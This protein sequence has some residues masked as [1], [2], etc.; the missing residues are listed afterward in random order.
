MTAHDGLKLIAFYLP[1]FHPI[2]ENDAWWGKG[3]TE[4]RNVAKGRPLFRGHYQPH[5]PADLGF[6]DLRLEDTRIAQAELARAHG[7]NGFCYYHYWFNGRELLERPFNEVL[8]SRQPDF[9]ICL[10]WANENWTRRWDGL[11]HDVLLG[12]NYS[13]EDDR[14]HIRSLFPAFEDSRYL[15][16]DGKPLFLVYRVGLFPEPRATAE[17]WREEASKAGIGEIFL[18]SVESIGVRKTPMDTGFDAA[19]EFA[20]D[21][22]VKGD[23]INQG[24]FPRL[25][26]KFG[27]KDFRR[28]NVYSYDSLVE[29]MLAKPLPGYKQFRGV[30]P[31]W[32]KTARRQGQADMWLGSTPEKYQAWLSHVIEQTRTR[33]PSG[34]QFV[35]INAWNEWAEGCHLEPDQKYGRAYLEATLRARLGG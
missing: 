2:P 11:D 28:Y 25:V 16:I 30:A 18:A 21:W 3:F 10:C 32:D 31:S 27:H 19:V 20:P 34:E 26:R 7:I 9:P 15:R 13:R 24:L 12:Q 8:R 23:P 29:N 5:L 33:L 17:L 6:Y 35:F 4:W 1:Q 22:F 14:A